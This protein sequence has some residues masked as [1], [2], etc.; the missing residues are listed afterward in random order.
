MW[1]RK[2]FLSIVGFALLVLFAITA[3]ADKEPVANLSKGGKGEIFFYGP[4]TSTFKDILVGGG[5]DDR[6]II[7]G[8]LKMPKKSSGKVPVAIISHGLS[9]VREDDS[10]V[11][12]AMNDI[13]MAAFII[14]H[15]KSRNIS[16]GEEANRKISDAMR[17]ADVYAALKVLS[18]HPE[19]DSHR[20]AVIGRSRGGST[21]LF[22]ASEKI[23]QSFCKGDLRFAAHVAFYPVCHVQFRNIKFTGAP[24]LMLLAEKDNITP[25]AMCMDYAKRIESSGTNVKIVVYKGAHH[26]FTS[27]RLS[28]QARSHPHLADYSNCLDRYVQLQDD[29]TW[30][31]PYMQKTFDKYTDWDELTADCQLKGKGKIGDPRRARKKSLKELQ[32]FFK[33]IFDLT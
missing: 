11:A 33:Q 16:S 32:T 25:A 4:N 31:F 9:G 14:D 28:G 13:G 23:R 27:P 26:A 7:F 19:I 15:N 20:I 12:R 3:Y 18:T 22:A 10:V 29:G 5:S 2:P 1:N 21:A 6:V 17:V 30:F 24:I 8:D